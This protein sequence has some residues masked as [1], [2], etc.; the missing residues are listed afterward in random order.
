MVV[1]MNAAKL[2]LLLGASYIG[3]NIRPRKEVQPESEKLQALERAE[4]KRQ[5]KNA[6]RVSK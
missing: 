6:K 4:L 3:E 1:Q 5:R 2:A